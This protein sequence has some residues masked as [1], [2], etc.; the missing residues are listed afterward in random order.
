MSGGTSTHSAIEE[1]AAKKGM[2]V[3]FP[4]TDELFIDIDNAEDW[5]KFCELVEPLKKE[6]LVVGCSWTTSKSGNPRKHVIVKLSRAVESEAERIALQAFL[7]SDRK[8]EMLNY[9][10]QLRH[11][12]FIATCFF[13][14]QPVQ[15]SSFDI[16]DH[17]EY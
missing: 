7:G 12:G 15:R 17:G 9:L 13:E 8:R 3:L 14:P 16:Y 11:P 5:Q 10:A 2:K 6:R 1:K 4:A